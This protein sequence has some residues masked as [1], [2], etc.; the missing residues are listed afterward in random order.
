[1][2]AARKTMLVSFPVAVLICL[3]AIFGCGGAGTAPDGDLLAIFGTARQ[4]LSDAES[5]RMMIEMTIDYHLSDILLV[6]GISEDDME[7]TFAYEMLYEKE[8][9]GSVARI[10]SDLYDYTTQLM[11]EPDTSSG[12]GSRLQKVEAYVTDEEVFYQ[13]EPGGAWMYEE[14]AE[15]EDFFS[16]L[17]QSEFSPRYLMEALDEYKGIEVVEETDAFIVFELTIDYQMGLG[18]GLS[19]FEGTPMRVKVDKESRLP[20]EIMILQEGNL[21][22]AYEEYDGEEFEDPEF[23]AAMEGSTYAFIYRIEFSDY[24]RDFDLR[25]PQEALDVKP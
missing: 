14:F 20:V 18:M 19:G 6:A 2:N 8:D 16:A 9:G 5:Y 7:M 25:I 12:E 21:A 24:G 4:N 11:D 1:M 10:T 17:Y 3:S 22:E 15:G 13:E 23:M